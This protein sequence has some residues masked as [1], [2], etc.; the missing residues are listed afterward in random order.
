MVVEISYQIRPGIWMYGISCTFETRDPAVIIPIKYLAT[1]EDTEIGKC[2]RELIPLAEQAK[3][4]SIAD[5]IVGNG[6]NEVPES[7]LEECAEDFQYLQR[8]AGQARVIDQSPRMYSQ[9]T[10]PHSSKETITTGST[11]PSSRVCKNLS[12]NWTPRWF[13]LSAMWLNKCS[14]S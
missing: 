12:Q 4:R 7:L 6:Q 1:L 8:F 14:R 5:W 2:A 9:D 11:R 3:A 10:N 13:L